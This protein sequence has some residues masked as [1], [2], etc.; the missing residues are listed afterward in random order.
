MNPSE[1]PD[2]PIG[3]DDDAL[4]AIDPDPPDL[5]QPKDVAGILND[6]YTKARAKVTATRQRYEHHA[7]E[8]IRE[9]DQGDAIAS[10]EHQGKA[11]R[12][13]K[14]WTF[15]LGAV[16]ALERLADELGVPLDDDRRPHLPAEN[17]T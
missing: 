13:H 2:S 8:A 16:A 17:R 9:R 11:L 4:V 14:N 15:G 7:D 3:V 5:S 6:H 12:Q 1:L 10:G